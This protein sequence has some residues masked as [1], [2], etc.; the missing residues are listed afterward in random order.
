[1]NAA[2][3]LTPD[4]LAALEEARTLLPANH[5]HTQAL[6][7]VLMQA[8]LSIHAMDYWDSLRGALEQAAAIID[9]ISLDP[10]TLAG[11]PITPDLSTPEQV[12]AWNQLSIRLSALRSPLTGPSVRAYC[13][14]LERRVAHLESRPDAPVV[15]PDQALQE[16]L[17][18][19]E[20]ALA[21]AHAYL[22]DRSVP[23]HPDLLERMRNL[24]SPGH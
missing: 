1:M 13:Q 4:Q 11:V 24:A 18:R 19:A 15:A 12:S 7:R 20:A 16:G 8:Q 9:K 10:P 22:N 23:Y 17:D 6:A 5:P 3:A 21:A 2:I 14:E